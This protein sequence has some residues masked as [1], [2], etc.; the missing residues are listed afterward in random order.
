MW[1]KSIQKLKHGL[2]S[3]QL[4]GC[5][6]N[7]NKRQWLTRDV[8]DRFIRLEKNNINA[9]G[10]FYITSSEE[11]FQERNREIVME[12]IQEKVNR[13]SIKP[14]ERKIRRGILHF[15]KWFLEVSDEVK[16]RWV[17]EK[18]KRSELKE[19]RRGRENTIE[20]FYRVC[21]KHTK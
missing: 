14:K 5:Q 3:I 11:R 1:T 18:R 9:K 7:F 16:K 8:K 20:H 12:K 21:N 13:A 15:R 10:E 2:M 4:T 6:S 17:E 19:K